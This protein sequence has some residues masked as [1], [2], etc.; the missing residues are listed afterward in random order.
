MLHHKEYAVNMLAAVGQDTDFQHQP[1]EH[2]FEAFIPPKAT[3]KK[4]DERPVFERTSR[5][6]S[7]LPSPSFLSGSRSLEKFCRTEE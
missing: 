3:K 7:L 4:A 6:L 1:A 2:R 5:T